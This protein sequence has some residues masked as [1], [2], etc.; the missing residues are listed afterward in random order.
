MTLELGSGFVVHGDRHDV[1][2]F[3]GMDE[4]GDINDIRIGRYGRSKLDR[5][6]KEP[7][8]IHV[9]DNRTLEPA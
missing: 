2:T 8:V 5:D 6:A 4:V 7:H 3:V 1:L 9:E